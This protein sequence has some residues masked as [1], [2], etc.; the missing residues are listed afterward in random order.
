MGVDDYRTFRDITGIN[1]TSNDFHPRRIVT[2][3]ESFNLED[4][5]N[6][7]RN[8]RRM[9]RSMNRVRRSLMAV[10]SS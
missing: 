2:F 9:Q 4:R 7:N 5:G 10:N 3:D 8:W 6:Y 1:F